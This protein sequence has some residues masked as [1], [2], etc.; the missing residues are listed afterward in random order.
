MIRIRRRERRLNELI[1]ISR[2]KREKNIYLFNQFSVAAVSGPISPPRWMNGKFPA[3]SCTT[4][5]NSCQNRD[6]YRWRKRRGASWSAAYKT[7]YDISTQP[8]IVSMNQSNDRKLNLNLLC[9]SWAASYPLQIQYK[10]IWNST[11]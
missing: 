6:R 1:I 3:A 8:C 5:T 4:L 7:M 9:S 2:R 10:Y 11:G